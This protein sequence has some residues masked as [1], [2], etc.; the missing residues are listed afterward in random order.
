METKLYE[1]VCA[2]YEHKTYQCHYFSQGALCINCSNV[3]YL[4]R[5]ISEKTE[6]TSEENT[7]ESTETDANN[8]E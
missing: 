7:K 2:R 3:R 4:P 1:V 8:G 5:Y 6:E